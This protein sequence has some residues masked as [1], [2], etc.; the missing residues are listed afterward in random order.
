MATEETM[1]RWK[2][3]ELQYR[4]Y[5]PEE[6]GGMSEFISFIIISLLFI[7]VFFA[8]DWIYDRYWS[9]TKAKAEVEVAL[10][11]EIRKGTF[12]VRQFVIDKNGYVRLKDV[13]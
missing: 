2:D 3:E 7:A 4:D 12:E 6:C 1:A 10:P 13:K 9:P 11:I 8:G 5:K